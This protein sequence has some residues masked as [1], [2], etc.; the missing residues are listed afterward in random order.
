MNK[1]IFLLLVMFLNITS[2][3]SCM[4]TATETSPVADVEQ[5]QSLLDAEITLRKA[6]MN[7]QS[8]A[9]TASEKLIEAQ[10]KVSTQSLS[11]FHQLI[12]LLKL[13]EESD[14]E[15]V[16]LLK[17]VKTLKLTRRNLPW[18]SVKLATPH[19]EQSHAQSPDPGQH[20]A[21]AFQAPVPVK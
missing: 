10:D 9:K 3:I 5:V 19:E 14:P 18:F 7:N 8:N 12:A 1:K 21:S 11:F 2:L 13:Q 6:L 15:H 17:Q 4:E 16:D 20:S